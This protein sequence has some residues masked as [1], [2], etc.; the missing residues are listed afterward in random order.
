MTRF[1]KKELDSNDY[2]RTVVLA[3]IARIILFP[4]FLLVRIVL[5]LVFLFVRI[6]RWVWDYD[7][8]KAF[9]R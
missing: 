4:I 1:T 9:K 5:T 7:Y 3:R 6:Y 2:R 8:T